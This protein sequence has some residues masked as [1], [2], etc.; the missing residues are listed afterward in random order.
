MLSNIT[1]LV[2]C[3]KIYFKLIIKKILLNNF[4]FYDL[5]RF[6]EEVSYII[7]KNLVLKQD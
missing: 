3:L 5:N 2:Q 6:L 7:G 1:Y 4:I